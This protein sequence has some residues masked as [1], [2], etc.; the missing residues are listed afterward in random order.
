MTSQ[1]GRVDIGF[2]FWSDCDKSQDPDKASPTLHRYHRLLW[3]KELPS[4]RR[5]E[6][7]DARPL[8]YLA[9]TSGVGDRF[10]LSS[11][12][13]VATYRHWKRP[14]AKRVVA[15]VPLDEQRSFYKLSYT[16]GGFV[17]FPRN[18]VDGLPSINQARGTRACLTS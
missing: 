18:R 16:M 8:G 17:L 5:L 11:D 1:A 13:I 6:L 4:G 7:E 10:D 2:N 14:E 9:G 15:G 12:A 3:G